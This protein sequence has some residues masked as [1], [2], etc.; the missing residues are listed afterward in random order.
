LHI[1]L[2]RQRR[3]KF[4]IYSG[5]EWHVLAPFLFAV[6]VIQIT[7]GPGMLFILAN[8]IAGGPRA[9]I[10]AAFGAATGMM[11]HTAA[12]A[13]GLAAMFHAAPPIYDAVRIGGACYLLWLAVDHFR[14]AGSLDD[15]D[16][17]ASRSS[18]RRVYAR[19]I[20]NNLANPKVI[21]FFVAFLPQFVVP[22][23]GPPT[24]Q[25]VIL[26]SMFLLV[27]LILDVIIGLLSGHLSQTLRRRKWVTKLLDRIAG[28]ILAGLGLRLA[29][30][31]NRP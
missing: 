10:A 23:A 7:P 8:G 2:V 16:P 21:L 27:G 3:R 31:D 24:L 29:L 17:P 22:G 26:G 5:M 9:G 13:A 15:L 11:V 14:S 18:T 12:A 4:G 19:A 30:N 20:V 6:L 25:F 1:A 28:T